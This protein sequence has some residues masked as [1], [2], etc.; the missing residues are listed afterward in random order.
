VSI[1]AAVASE[2]NKDKTKNVLSKECT[3]KDAT[4]R[5]PFSISKNANI[6][7]AAK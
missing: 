5:P 3:L 6:V 7:G 1:E 2:L 4:T